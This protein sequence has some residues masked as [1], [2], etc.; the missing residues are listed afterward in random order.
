MRKLLGI[1]LLLFVY[2]GCQDI[3]VGYLD[4]ANAAY[5]PDSLIV[6]THLDSAGIDA[7]RVKTG[8]PWMSCQIEGVEGTKQIFF[9]IRSVITFDGDKDSM[10]KWLS[11][12][13]DG[14]F[15]IP[16]DHEIAPGR[17]FIS[18]DFENEGYKKFKDA[19]FTIIV[20]E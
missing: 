5:S 10:L 7:Q 18:L 15:I 1:V 20:K 6:R 13:N 3:T 12:R 17:Y 19:L 8:Q 9:S 14:T 16:L 11:V 2:W 4:V